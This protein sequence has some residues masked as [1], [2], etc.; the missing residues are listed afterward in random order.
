[1]IYWDRI[2][3]E[4]QFGEGG[5]IVGFILVV[6]VWS[7]GE[8]YGEDVYWADKTQENLWVFYVNLGGPAATE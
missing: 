1:M 8:L 5:R 7:A 6:C 3:T 4:E 2:H